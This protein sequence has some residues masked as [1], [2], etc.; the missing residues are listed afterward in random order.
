MSERRSAVLFVLLA[1]VWGTSFMAIKAGLEAFPPVLFAALRY[2]LAA[3][4]MVG[5]A[6]VTCDYWLP[7]TRA[8]WLTLVVEGVLIIALYNAFLFVGETGVTSGVAAILVGMSPILSTVFS[9]LFLPD[10]RLTV[11]GTIG[12]LLGFVGVAMVARPTSSN[13]LGSEAVW[14]GLVLLAAASVALGSV[15]VQRLDGDISPEG[16]VAWSNVIGAALLHTISLGLPSESF[17][18]AQFSLAGVAA[19]VYLAVFASA[20]GYVVYFDLLARLGAI[21]INLVSYAAPIFAAVSGWLAL[22]ETLELLDVAGFVVIFTGFV[23]LKRHALATELS[24]VLDRVE[25]LLPGR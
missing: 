5:Y 12:L 22:D 20:I 18:D 6:A 9:R 17:A 7:R 16:M 3:V 25:G 1:A 23:L 13:P 2:D 19:L 21:E 8:D 14:P 11:V 15:L 24:P 4:L 10:Q